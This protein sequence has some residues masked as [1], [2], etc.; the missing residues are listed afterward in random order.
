MSMQLPPPS[1]LDWN[2]ICLLHQ[3]LAYPLPMS[4]S[5]SSLGSSIPRNQPSLSFCLTTTLTALV[6]AF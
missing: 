5:W 1:P 4:V 6:N 2:N 3:G